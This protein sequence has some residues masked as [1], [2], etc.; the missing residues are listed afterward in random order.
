MTPTQITQSNSAAPDGLAAHS[1]V[2]VAADANEVMRE[3]LDYLIEHAHG[4]PCGCPQCVRYLRARSVLLE[5][6]G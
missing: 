5:V 6:F 1:R 4:G 3:Q 2:V